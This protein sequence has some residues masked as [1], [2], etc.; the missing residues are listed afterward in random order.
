MRQADTLRTAID[1]GGRAVELVIRRNKRAR[2]MVLRIARDG[3][4]VHL[5]IPP[6]GDLTAALTFAE[7]K[8]D[9][10]AT[11]LAAR[12]APVPFAHGARI[13]FRGET[14]TVFHHPGRRRGAVWR[15]GAGAA[16]RICVCGAAEHLPRRLA[17]W[18]KEQAKTAFAQAVRAYAPAMG[19]RVARITV[20]DQQSRWGSC[21]SKGNLNFSWRLIMAPPLVLDYIAAHEVA[22][23]VHMNHS[24]DFW[25]L[26]KAHCPHTDA[27]E[28]WLAAHGAELHRYGRKG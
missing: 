18:L 20:R 25:R 21:S 15:E 17:D 10:I 6:R 4:H 23:L 12:P 3:S 26:V 14:H 1:I 7:G 5:S 19:V 9:W 13:P 24:A 16:A 2:N 8:R 27:A 28:R 11:R 22:H